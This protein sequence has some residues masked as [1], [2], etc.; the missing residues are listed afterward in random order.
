MQDKQ[1]LNA[2]GRQLWDAKAAF[3]DSLHGDDG[4][5]F[6]RTLIAPSVERLLDVKSGERV[7]DVACG[8]GVMVR[9]LAELGAVM[10]ATDF[11]A[12]LIERAKARGQ[13]SGHPIDYRVV[14]ATDESALVAL[15]EFDA[16]VCTMALMDIPDIAPLF[17][18]ARRML[19]PGGRFVFATSHP[20]FNSNNPIFYAEIED[21]NGELIHTG[22][23]KISGY[24]DI[25]PTKA[26]GAID[27]PNPHYYYHRPLH[28][29]LG[30]AF[31]AGLVLNGLEEIGFPREE[32][33][34]AREL[35][36]SKMWQ[37]P[38]VMAGR[39]VVT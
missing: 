24:L 17:R 37:I 12:G 32:A 31:R 20:A 14:D 4:N 38:P 18:A 27:E 30:E 39:F 26:V 29:L 8:N 35:S 11:S 6:H 13:R 10:T 3:W 34:Q 7:L 1:A 22:G 16:M 15:G 23:V 25:P 19:R 36:W 5:V 28:E 21:R 9:R 33:D 2:E